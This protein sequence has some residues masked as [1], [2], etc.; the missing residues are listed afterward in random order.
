[1]KLNHLICPNCNFDFYTSADYGTCSACQYSFYASASRQCVHNRP[2]VYTPDLPIGT[3]TRII[4]N[5]TLSVYPE[6]YYTQWSS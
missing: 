5:A 6:N 2:Y 3:T 4:Q 1:M